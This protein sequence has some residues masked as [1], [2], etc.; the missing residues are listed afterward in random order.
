MM[1]C[2]AERS[3]PEQMKAVREEASTSGTSMSKPAEPKEA[4][5]VQEAREPREEHYNPVMW[6]LHCLSSLC[7]VYSLSMQWPF[8]MLCGQP[9]DTASPEESAS[10]GAEY[11]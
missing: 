11:F 7:V 1:L 5:I 9:A 8:A 10:K 4:E 3:S 2:L 6:C